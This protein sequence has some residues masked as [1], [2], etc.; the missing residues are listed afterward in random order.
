VP[1]RLTL[2]G[3]GRPEDVRALERDARALGV[4]EATTFTGLVRD[5]TPFYD[6]A[7][8]VLSCSASEAYGRVVVEAMKRGAPVIGS[9]AGGTVEQL[10]DSGGGLLYE[11]GNAAALA[12][13]IRRLHEDP[14]LRRRLAD[15]GRAWATATFTLEHFAEEFLAVAREALAADDARRAP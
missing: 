15:D 5:A 14:E 1:A 6:R 11:P 13:A 4:A 12:D 3:T 7:D 8:V 2:V 10:T 9:N